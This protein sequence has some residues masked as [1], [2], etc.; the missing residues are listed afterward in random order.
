MGFP[1]G[2]S[3]D[4]GLLISPAM[5]MGRPLTSYGQPV[6]SQRASNE[7][8]DGMPAARCAMERRHWFEIMCHPIQR[9]GGCSIF[10]VVT[11]LHNIGNKTSKYFDRHNSM[12]TAVFSR[13]CIW[14]RP[15]LKTSAVPVH[16]LLAQSNGYPYYGSCR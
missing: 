2:R 6:G 13:W 11:E 16:I 1:K 12:P 3:W 5:L 9:L 8:S 15:S 14:T 10:S 4:A 7:I